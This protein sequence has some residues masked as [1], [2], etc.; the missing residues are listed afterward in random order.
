[1]LV[2][3]LLGLVPPFTPP[4]GGIAQPW[5]LPVTLA[6]S[7]V[8]LIRAGCFP[9]D[10][11]VRLY[12][13][14]RQG[15]SAFVLSLYMIAAP[16]LLA[17]MLVAAPFDAGSV[18]ALALLGALAL[19]LSVA[20]PYLRTHP[21]VWLPTS[22]FVAMAIIGFS[23]ASRSPIAAAGAVAVML[24][25]ML[26][27]PTL[28]TG[29]RFLRAMI[30]AGALPGVWLLAQGAL[31]LHYGVVAVLLLPLLVVICLR[32]NTQHLTP[33]TRLSPTAVILVLVAIYPQVLAEFA[34]RPA[35]GA[36]A[37]GV[38]ALTSLRTDWGVGLAVASGQEAIVA[39]LPATGVA[40]A[41]FLVW[42][43]QFW[44]RQIAARFLPTPAPEAKVE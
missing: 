27:I 11:W 5:S 43:A 8:V 34:L 31:G 12:I 7:A 20:V 23:L 19:L 18:W 28:S 30:F 6:M 24:S 15:L 42:V 4:A 40:V 32:L 9:F 25:A 22:A 41:I 36:M 10:G 39:S 3:I 17:R 14:E 44:L 33:N 1:L 29:T 37:G 21:D 35:V 2:A 38:G 26:C 16:A 13:R